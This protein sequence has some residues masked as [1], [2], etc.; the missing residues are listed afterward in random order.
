MRRCDVDRVDLRIREQKLISGM[1]MGDAELVAEA[2]CRRL[3]AA[4]YSD[5]NPG[6]RLGKCDRERM[7]DPSGAEDSPTQ[8]PAHQLRFSRLPSSCLR[9]ETLC[10]GT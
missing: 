3:V 10:P 5:E 1:P 2:V 9:P 4:R 8:R 6:V 7:G